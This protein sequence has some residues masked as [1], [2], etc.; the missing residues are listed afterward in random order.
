MNNN[1]NLVIKKEVAYN[2]EARETDTTCAAQSA[3]ISLVLHKVQAKIC[4]SYKSHSSSGNFL[5]RGISSFLFFLFIV[6]WTCNNSH[7]QGFFDHSFDCKRDRLHAGVVQFSPDLSSLVLGQNCQIS[8]FKSNG[9][10]VDK[11]VAK[12]KEKGEYKVVHAKIEQAN[13]AEKQRLAV[14][15][16]KEREAQQA[17]EVKMKN[18]SKF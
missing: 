3:S 12:R 16:V 1:C 9:K 14:A 11:E 17:R 10:K 5:K 8:I 4:R 2:C 18:D 15:K 6:I 13:E 7:A